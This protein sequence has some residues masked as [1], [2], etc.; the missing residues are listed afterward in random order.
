MNHCQSQRKTSRIRFRD[1]KKS[2]VRAILQCIF[3]KFAL[4]F[5]H[6][7]KHINIQKKQV[8]EL[9]KNGDLFGCGT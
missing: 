5:N 6:N 1:C 7:M 2:I 3:Q 9:P 8:L 4:E